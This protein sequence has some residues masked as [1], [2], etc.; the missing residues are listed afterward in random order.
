[1]TVG[2]IVVQFDGIALLSDSRLMQGERV[3][4]DESQK[5][6]KVADCG[7]C[8]HVG[9]AGHGTSEVAGIMFRLGERTANKSLV[10]IA[11]TLR[12][13]AWDE[14]Q[15]KLKPGETASFFLAG[16]HETMPGY[17][18][19][20]ISLQDRMVEARFQK[21]S[22]DIF[23]SAVG[24]DTFQRLVIGSDMFKGSQNLHDTLRRGKFLLHE[25]ER[26][27]IER[28]GRASFG[29]NIQSAVILASGHVITPA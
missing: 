24:D 27:V 13:I 20:T 12:D 14:W 16:I 25:A 19:I 4:S 23:T 21:S 17:F 18:R 2:I 6:F 9:F 1:M 15:S 22:T 5:I 26:W 7:V 11:W 10:E 28:D 3:V 8:L 29:G